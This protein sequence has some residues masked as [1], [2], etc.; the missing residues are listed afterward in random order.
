MAFRKSP[1]CRFGPGDPPPGA[2]TDLPAACG[3]IRLDAVT[4]QRW[5]N[6]GGWTRELFASPPG[7]DRRVRVSVAEV[8]ADGPFSVFP[9]VQRWFCVLSGGGV[10]LTVDAR[11]LLLKVGDA[12]VGFDGGAPT[13]CRL[14][15]GPTRDLNLMVR[16]G[17]GSMTAVSPGRA[18]MPP[19]GPCGLY[20]AVDGVCQ[21]IPV[22]AHSLLWWGGA[23]GRLVFDPAS[24]SH[25]PAGWWL[26]AARLEPS[27]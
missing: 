25:G 12:P 4:P 1:D 23:A 16:G 19:P 15:D 14:I 5:R 9:G 18:W 2:G 26:G 21:G 11:A 27:A 3:S 10:E 24:A 8:E 17:P 20:A 6:G 13:N 22:S 7:A